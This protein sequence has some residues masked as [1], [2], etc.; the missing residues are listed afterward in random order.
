MA[1]KT[2]LAEPIAIVG[3]GCRFASGADSPSK[4]WQLLENPTDL[5]REIPASRFNIKSFY[6]P[7]GEHHGTTDS[8]NAYF[9]EQDHRVFDAAFFNI[10][11]KEAEAIDPQ[12]RLLLEVVYETMESAGYTIHQY[13]GRKVAVF[14]GVMTADYDTLS[15]RDDLVTSQYYATGN[16]RSIVS[17]RISYFFN[18]MGPSMTI[19]TACSSSLVA[20]HQAVLSLRSGESEMAC[21]TGS[22]MILTPEHFVVESS[23]HM[24][25]PAGHCRMWDVGAN[26]YARGEG[27]AAMFVKLLSKALA[28]GDQIE[29]IIRE[30]GANADGRS[31]GITMPNWEAQSALIQDTYRRAGLNAK[32]AEDRCQYFEAHGTGTPAGDPNE[33]KAIN[34]AFFIGT[35]DKPISHDPQSVFLSNVVEQNAGVTVGTG[36]TATATPKMV[37]GSIKT[38]IGHAEGAAGMAGVLKVVLSMKNSSIPPN[39]H[40]QRL[41][42]EVSQYCSNLVVPTKAIPWPYLFAG[43]PMRASV[44]SFG[45]GGSNAHAIIEQYVPELHDDIA[46]Q[47]HLDVTL[48]T[49]IVLS[50]LTTSSQIKLPL[51]LSAASLKS[52]VAVVR[53][54]RDYL[55]RTPLPPLGD[56]AWHSYAR[57][58][59]FPFRLAVS[60]GTVSE[61]IDKLSI[62]LE[63]GVNTDAKIGTRARAE[64][65][66]PRVLGIF[67]GQ[68]AQWATM[69][70]SLLGASRVYAKTIRTLDKVLETCPHPPSWTLEQEI[71]ADEGLS[72]I[73]RAAISQ[74]LCT[75]VQIA[76]VDLLQSLNVTFHTVIGHSSGEIAAAY[77]SG[78]I[79]A[80]DAILIAYY[81]GLYAHLAS[82]ADGAKGGML[83]VGLSKE[84]AAKLC[85]RGE[86]NQRIC[87]AASNSPTSITLSGDMDI[88]EVVRDELVAQRQFARMLNV[89]TAYH[90]PHMELP[91]LKYMEA[92]DV[93]SIT[94][95]TGS[96]KSVW[97]SSVYGFG[98]PQD[99]LLRSEYWK[100]NM[101]KPV[102]F[103]E[104]LESAI[105]TQGPFDCAIEIGPHPALR[106]P[107]MQTIEGKMNDIMPYSGLL[108]RKAD[109][110]VAIAQFLGWMWTQFASS[111]AQIRQFVLGSVEPALV[112]TRIQDAPLYPW[113]HSQV[114]YRESR[115]ARQYHFRE[116]A[117]HELLGSRSRDDNQYQLRW[118]NVLKTSELPWTMHHQFQGQILLPASAYLLMAVDAARVILAGRFAS[119]IELE[120]LAFHSGMI[121]E[122][123]DP[124]GVEALFSLIVHS[125]QGEEHTQ[126]T[127]EASFT[128]ESAIADGRTSM[129]QNFSGRLR[130]ALGEA[131]PEA[132]PSRP[133]QKA[134]TMPASPESFYHMM[135][136]TGLEYSGPFRGLTSLDRR[137]RF[138]SGRVASHHAEDTTNLRIS[139]ATLDS[140]LQTAFVAVSSPGDG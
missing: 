48:P 95:H 14:S 114:H 55:L 73:Q 115:I 6:H 8:P 83:V 27:I 128:L 103:S 11:P 33:A 39:L 123:N 47:F 88:L 126:K 15:Q 127:I 124:H 43:Q 58:T 108:N 9:V 41:N 135:E 57:R 120:D 86:Y 32:V 129:K 19:D 40:L 51:V 3:T 64:N 90:S 22:N 61:W 42:P 65:E 76:L 105:E 52:M 4:L 101:V 133:T 36:A 71:L 23:L 31:K 98:E 67:T 7:D 87:I 111:S 78:R 37:V 62:L 107:T 131:A 63:Q 89:D 13:A 30:T 17:N 20:L 85:A 54:Y 5:S 113:D 102:L 132:L 80:R 130:I 24:L 104:A 125:A 28:D 106:G 60:G 46:K 138:A 140:C 66:H 18:F 53:T 25:S 75:A 68:G 94:P 34:D 93:C 72:R 139:P 109:D 79:S 91:A 38:V 56:L 99:K 82:G 29:A 110:C 116:D 121:L 119:T 74:P 77:A 2:P 92:L 26:G 44:N 59:A 35:S 16:A 70:R 122:E 49:P 118:R 136:G 96:R 134:E 84:A 97:I 69:S 1:Y 12:Q 112:N 100:A 117:P 137:F 10:S 45:F 21:V 81:R 50:T